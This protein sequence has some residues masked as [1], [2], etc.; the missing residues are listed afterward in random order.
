MF[1]N[2]EYKQ[3]LTFSVEISSNTL[4]TQYSKHLWIDEQ[5]HT[6]KHIKSLHDSGKGYR[7]FAKLL[8]AEGSRTAK[9]KSG[10]THMFIQF[11]NDMQ[12][13]KQV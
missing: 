13:E 4:I 1:L 2:K 9:I 5:E 3:Y 8:N 10:R 6:H 11:L 7:T 12:N